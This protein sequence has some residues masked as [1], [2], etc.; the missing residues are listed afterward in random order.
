MSV[1]GCRLLVAGCRLL[2]V[3]CRF[4]IYWFPVIGY[5]LSVVVF[6]DLLIGC[7]L[8][9]V[10]GCWLLS[11]YVFDVLACCCWFSVRCWF[12]FVVVG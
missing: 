6:L 10:V 2:V 12:G 8:V 1:V 7:F 9:L 3:V 11:V 5:C 4:W